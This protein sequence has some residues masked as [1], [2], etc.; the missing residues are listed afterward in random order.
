MISNAICVE[1]VGCVEV[2][3]GSHEVSE[4]KKN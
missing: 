3:N 2:D 1:E 4:R